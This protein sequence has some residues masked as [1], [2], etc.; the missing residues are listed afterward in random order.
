MAKQLDMKK[1]LTVLEAHRKMLKFCQYIRMQPVSQQD[2]M[3]LFHTAVEEQKGSA[4]LP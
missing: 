2:R 4:D 1:K 3:R